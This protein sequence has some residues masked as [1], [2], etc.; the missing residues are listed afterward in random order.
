MT[1]LPD[2]AVH[3]PIDAIDLSDLLPNDFQAFVLTHQVTLTRY[4][5]QHLGSVQDAERA[6]ADVLVA[7]F[8]Q[9][10]KLLRSEA[11][12]T[13]LA[14]RL[15]AEHLDARPAPRVPA[16]RD[17]AP[18]PPEKATDTT[19]PGF[20]EFAYTERPELIRYAQR[21]LGSLHDAEDIVSDV[22]L[23]MYKRWNTLVD[24]ISPPRALAFRMLQGKIVDWRRRHHHRTEIHVDFTDP[25]APDVASAGHDLGDPAGFVP[26]RAFLE[27]AIAAMPPKRA[28]CAR[29]HLVM[30]IPI[31]DVAAYLGVTVSTVRSH[32]HIARRQ[33]VMVLDGTVPL[34]PTRTRPP[35]GM[36]A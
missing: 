26:E 14:F 31:P 22:M 16:Q 5:F 28:A 9:W 10:D 30:Q 32:V 12:P 24:H 3:D 21:R 6:V 25:D 19:C 17:P 13:G 7:L 33:L 36:T 29:L 4:A 34:D 11:P 15:L 27:G 18:E 2:H 1:E 35:Q 20:V 8:R 23:K